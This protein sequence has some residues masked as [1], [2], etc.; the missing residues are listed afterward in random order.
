[1]HNIPKEKDL[2]QLN[3]FPEFVERREEAIVQHL[4]DKFGPTEHEY[5]TKSMS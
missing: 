3:N 1:M 4:L 5:A 2:Y